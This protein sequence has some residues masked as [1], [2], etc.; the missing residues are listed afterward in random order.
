MWE[1]YDELI[2]AVPAHSRVRHAVAGLHW[3]AVQAESLGL[4]MSPREGAAEIA[5]AG[6]IAGM[7]TRDLAR[8]VKSWNWYEAAIG[9]AAINAALNAPEGV[10]A[11]GLALDGGSCDD[12]FTFLME[13]MRGK[14]VAVVGHF[15]NLQR[16]ADICDLAILERR[17]QDGD[18]PDPACEYILADRDIV[19]VTATTL[20]NKTL[21]RL[22]QLCR[23]T[24][25]VVAGPSTPLTPLLLDRGVEMLGGL[26]VHDAEK[27]RTLVAEGGHHDIFGPGAQMV[28][29]A[30]QPALR[31][32]R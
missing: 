2:E 21:P 27:I 17:P 8:W 24:R 28:K 5:G 30:R 7:A 22:L 15:R 32:A 20:I 4:A 29:L 6:R 14:R 12:V 9:L 19:I 13:E 16:V 23:K 3:C 25:V 31:E 18:L 1:I 10:E 11:C 26:V